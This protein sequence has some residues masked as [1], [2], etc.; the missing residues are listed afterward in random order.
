MSSVLPP[1]PPKPGSPGRSSQPLAP[2]AKASA[3]AS[4]ASRAL[5][6]QTRSSTKAVLTLLLSLLLLSGCYYAH[7]ARGQARLLLARRDIDAVLSDPATAP[8]I[9]S[10]LLRVKA[11]RAYARELGLDVGGQYT[12]YAEWPGNRVVTTV[13][14]TAPGEIEPTPFGFPLVGEV[15]YKGYFDVGAAEREAERLRGA[16]YDV[17]LVPVPAYSTLG[18]FDDPVTTPLLQG[19]P[20]DLVETLLH[21]LVHA[22]VFVRSDADF[23]EGLA[24]FYAQEATLRFFAEQELAAL[25]RERERIRERRD[26]AALLAELRQAVAEL[27]ASE[28]PVDADSREALSQS[29]RATLA[30]LPLKRNDP[31]ALAATIPLGDACLALVG[32][33]TADLPAYEGRLQALDGDLGAFLDQ[34]KQAA[35]ASD[36]RAS[37]LAPQES[38]PVRDSLPAP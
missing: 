15:P 9:R 31:E 28:S 12:S 13:V 18:W 10:A 19:D 17:C 36:P 14:I 24:T 7:L 27:Y 34:A 2:A 37:L 21:E 38:A 25:P 4:S 23:N 6:T 33:Y 32:T 11:V 20:G 1:L 29:A 16:G 26:V 3:Q 8:E 5:A 22:T 30:S 35:E